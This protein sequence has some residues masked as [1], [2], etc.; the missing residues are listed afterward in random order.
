M[1]FN[2]GQRV[3]LNRKLEMSGFA[4]N[5]G[6]EGIVANVHLQTSVLFDG[7]DQ[8]LAVA[9]SDLDTLTKAAGTARAS[10]I[11]TS[12]AT[13]SAA[14]FQVGQRVRLLVPKH[15]GGQ[16]IPAGCLGTV[17]QDAPSM[18]ASWV[19]FDGFPGDKLIPNSDIQSA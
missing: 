9:D 3:R 16:T 12:T 7:L 4:V 10:A 18:N 5:K 15:L 2:F 13:S 8:E 1:P 17:T 6:M 11:T 19:L 14:G